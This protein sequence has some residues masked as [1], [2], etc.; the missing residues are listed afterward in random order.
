MTGYLHAG[1]A[2]SLSFA[3][4]PNR[5]PLSGAWLL[6]R[7]IP[8][9]SHRD[10][11]GCYPLLCCEDW[12][13]LPA[14][15]EALGTEVVSVVAVA[16]PFGGHGGEAGLR[17]AF[18]EQ[19][20]P[21]KEH[22][23]ADLRESPDRFVSPH[24]RRNARRALASLRVEPVAEPASALDEWV[25]LYAVLTA[26]H[27]ITGMAAFPREAFRGQLGVPG[28]V[29]L[30]ASLDGVTVG[31]TL[32]FRHGDRAYY[33]LGAYRE[34]GYAHGAAFALFRTAMER[35]ADAGV[36]WLALGAGA[37]VRSDADDGLSRFKR[38]WANSTRTAFLCG[39]VCDPARYAALIARR[40]GGGETF[41]PAYRAPATAA[42]LAAG[43]A[44]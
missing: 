4:V 20:L 10:A 1:Y 28:L 39:R 33:H 12:G 34:A 19:V 44:P 9:T 16:D 25:E 7:E 27:R 40:G 6:E 24:H 43:V 37:G 11:T 35:F 3:G 32:W 15:L 17:A 41:F 29:A 36:R 30:R 2:A 31:M 14:D 22:F 38:G 26:R 8:G 13:A 18:P 5:L 42:G 23:V 21:F